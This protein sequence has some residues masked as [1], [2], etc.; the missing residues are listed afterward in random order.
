[1]TT[2]GLARSL[3]TLFFERVDE[4]LPAHRASDVQGIVEHLEQDLVASANAVK[5]EANLVS[6]TLSMRLSRSA[7]G[8][9]ADR[10]DLLERTI[11]LIQTVL[12]LDNQSVCERQVSMEENSLVWVEFENKIDDLLLLIDI[13][14]GEYEMLEVSEFLPPDIAITKANAVRSPA[15]EIAMF[16][17]RPE[18]PLQSRANQQRRCR[19]IS[20]QKLRGGRH[21]DSLGTTV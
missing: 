10:A 16:V 7:G 12:A 1:L 4:I 17:L 2:S 20:S 5:D 18:L 13:E 21:R 8:V 15:R 3:P 14:H 11:G 6:R 9:R 19:I